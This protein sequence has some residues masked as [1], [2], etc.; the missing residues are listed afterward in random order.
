MTILSFNLTYN[1]NQLSPFIFTRDG[2]GVH[3]LAIDGYNRILYAEQNPSA[4]SSP[5][6]VYPNPTNAYEAA[7]DAI[8]QDIL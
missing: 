3:V 2:D 1:N 4:I 6:N 5:I 8:A 7:V